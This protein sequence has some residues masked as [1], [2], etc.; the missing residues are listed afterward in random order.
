M[1]H[2]NSLKLIIRKHSQIWEYPGKEMKLEK[3]F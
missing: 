3:P 1:F 2:I